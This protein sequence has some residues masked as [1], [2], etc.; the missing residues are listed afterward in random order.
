VYL[1][2]SLGGGVMT[3]LAT[4]YP[5]AALILM[6]TFTGLREAAGVV[7]PFL[8]GLLVPDAFPSRRRIGS[9]RSPVLIMHGDNDE[10]LPVRM[11]HELYE[12]APEPKRLHIYPGGC[13]NDLILI[14][15]W[16]PTVAEWVSSVLED[17]PAVSE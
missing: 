12:A 17:S 9:L 13:H 3:E 5:P 8:P 4:C 16:A 1:G 2:K 15:S 14:P 11:G 6:S 10:L 7:Y